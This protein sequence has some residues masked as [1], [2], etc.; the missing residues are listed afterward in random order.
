MEESLF[1]EAD[2]MG[3]ME[4]LANENDVYS[5]ALIKIEQSLAK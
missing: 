4:S 2:Q 5:A 3:I 1:A